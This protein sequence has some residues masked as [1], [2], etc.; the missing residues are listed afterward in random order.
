MFIGLLCIVP[1]AQPPSDA[2]QGE[3]QAGNMKAPKLHACTH[4]HAVSIEHTD[5]VIYPM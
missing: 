5:C 4:V 3:V 2:K 1:L